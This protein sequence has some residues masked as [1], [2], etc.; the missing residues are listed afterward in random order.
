MSTGHRQPSTVLYL[1]GFAS[2]PNSQKIR[3]LRALL[4]PMG[5]ELN[6]PDLNV[7]SFEKLD[8]EEM[9][10]TAGKSAGGTMAAIVGSSLGSVVALEVVRRGLH[11]PM[12]LIAPGLGIRDQWLAKL[13]PGDPIEIFNFARGENMPI[14]RAFFEQ[15]SRV[16]AD[17]EPP[18][19]P[20]TIFMGRKD[21]TIA[22]HRVESV[23][24]SWQ[25]SGKL[26][27]GS[28]F[29]GIPE[30]DHGLTAFVD[31]IAP[32]I[33]KASDILNRTP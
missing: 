29:I 11:V 9:V 2:S 15:M 32:E 22:F 19:V 24:K 17:R 6:T 26:A 33:H 3:S 4:A 21:E 12:V 27:P 10:K 23:W 30:G 20:V 31:R 13:P 25:S 28:K 5:V 8:F 18:P 16:D 14:H 7:P 1:H